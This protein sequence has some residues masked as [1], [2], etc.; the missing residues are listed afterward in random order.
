M[1]DRSIAMLNICGF[2]NYPLRELS[3]S[4][5]FMCFSIV[6]ISIFVKAHF[7]LAFGTFFQQVSGALHF[8]ILIVGRGYLET[9]SGFILLSIVAAENVSPSLQVLILC[10]RFTLNGLE[11]QL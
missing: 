7:R 3:S 1:N 5:L 9:W 4:Q 8:V 10:P 2:W 6:P 11:Y